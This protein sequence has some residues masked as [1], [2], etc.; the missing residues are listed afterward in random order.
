MSFPL[1]PCLGSEEGE[2]ALS[3]SLG[4]DMCSG[5]SCG[6]DGPT[7]SFFDA[8]ASTAADSGGSGWG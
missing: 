4:G 3:D 5:G 2:V 8:R 6:R 7:E 1:P